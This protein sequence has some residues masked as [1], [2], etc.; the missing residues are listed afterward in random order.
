MV[1][2]DAPVAS[3]PA[4]SDGGTVEGPVSSAEAILRR[5]EQTVIDRRIG[6]SV[7]WEDLD[8]RI[9]ESGYRLVDG[10]VIVE[11]DIN[12][13]TVDDVRSRHEQLRSGQ[14]DK[15]FL[16][17]KPR[18]RW[19]H[20]NIRWRFSDRRDT[21]FSVE[22]QALVW[23]AINAWNALSDETGITFVYND[24]LRRTQHGVLFATGDSPSACHSQFGMLSGVTNVTLGR[25]CMQEQRAIQHEIGHALGLLHEHTR[26]DRDTALTVYEAMVERGFMSLGQYRVDDAQSEQL[27]P[28]DVESNMIYASYNGFL[29]TWNG[30]AG[31]LQFPASLSRETTNLWNIVRNPAASSLV[32]LLS[33]PLDPATSYDSSEDSEEVTEERLF[34]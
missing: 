11:G 22:E 18:R 6:E 34:T 33:H 7:L 24:R 21:D 27:G 9:V 15:A 5:S 26:R 13:G 16:E 14:R 29:R 30:A 4:G 32:W 23:T 10:W 3:T 17:N 31:L 19:D 25:A 20:T 1:G 28:L 2:C 8:G 12:L